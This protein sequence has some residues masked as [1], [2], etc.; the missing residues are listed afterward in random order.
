M[1]GQETKFKD[2]L[3]KRLHEIPNSMFIRKPTGGQWNEGIGAPDI[4]GCIDGRLIFIECK[5]GGNYEVTLHQQKWLMQWAMAD[6][7]CFIFS[8]IGEEVTVVWARKMQISGKSS[9]DISSVVWEELIK[10]VI[11]LPVTQF[12]LSSISTGGLR[13]ILMSTAFHAVLLEKLHSI[14]LAG[15]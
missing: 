1:K 5:S 7:R 2:Q 4:Y 11:L 6:A 10:Q 15:R 8:Q 9:A 14:K 3:M 13:Q 12:H